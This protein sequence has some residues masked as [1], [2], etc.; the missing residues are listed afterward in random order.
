MRYEAKH[1]YF[2]H[3]AR[4]LGNFKNIPLTLARRHQRYMC[5]QLSIPSE[6]LRHN[7]EVSSGTYIY[8]LFIIS[9]CVV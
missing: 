6:Y 1:S 8:K 4:V 9:H 2:K 3:M 7:L 5:Y